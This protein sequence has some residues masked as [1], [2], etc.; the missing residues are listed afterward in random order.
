M[1]RP[2]NAHASAPNPEAKTRGGKLPRTC[3]VCGALLPRP[4]DRV[5]LLAVIAHVREQVGNT[6]T[7]T[8]ERVLAVRR[9]TTEVLTAEA[10]QRCPGCQD[11]S[12]D[13]PPEGAV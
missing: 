7:S 2:R 11:K 9:T 1:A 10:A 5:Q 3:L 13:P 12:L 6:E 8:F 4:R